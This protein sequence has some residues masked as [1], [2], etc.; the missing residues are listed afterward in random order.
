MHGATVRKEEIY[1]SGFPATCDASALSAIRPIASSAERSC[2]A[3]DWTVAL[4]GGSDAPTLHREVFSNQTELGGGEAYVLAVLPQSALAAATSPTWWTL[5]IM[6]II[7][8]FFRWR[9]PSVV[10]RF[11]RKPEAA[12]EQTG[13][14]VLF[15]TRAF[16]ASWY[17]G[18]VR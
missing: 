18:D 5:N 9:N 3:A 16:D 14:R 12:L 1:N 7:A 4:A 13:P 10:A 11:Q 2:H 17:T 8:C 15:N 6:H